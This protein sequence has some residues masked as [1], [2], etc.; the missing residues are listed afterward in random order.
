MSRKRSRDEWLEEFRAIG[1]PC[2]PVYTIDEVFN[3]PHLLNRGML[4]EMDH[5]EA[6]RIKQISPALKFSGTP[7]T[8]GTPPPRLGEHT[9]EVLMNIA[10]YTHEEI[11]ELAL[12][13]AI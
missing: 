11:E 3:D 1:F 10:G 9:V 12:A 5:L 2:G 6:G 8:T 4:F 13:G 7:C